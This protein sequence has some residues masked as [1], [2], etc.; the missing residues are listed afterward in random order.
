MARC[1]AYKYIDAASVVD[2]VRHG[3][4]IENVPH[5]SQN[6]SPIGRQKNAH[7][8]QDGLLLPQN[9]RQARALTKFESDQ[10]RVIWLEAVK[11]APKGK[12]SAPA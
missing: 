7:H 9:E 11:T 10:Q 5:G 6:L 3:A 2:N 12:I 1:T 4:Q 8:E